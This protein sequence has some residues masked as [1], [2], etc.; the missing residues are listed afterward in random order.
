MRP[1]ARPSLQ[2]S[3]VSPPSGG[4]TNWW[5]PSYDPDRQLV[6]V[7]A[8]DG[9]SLY[10]KGPV[11]FEKGKLFL[12]SSADF[13]ANSPVTAAVRAVDA[14]TGEVSWE[15]VLEHGV[16]NVLRKVGGVLSTR[17]GVLLVGYK[18]EFAAYDSSNGA[19]LWSVGLGGLVGGPPIAYAVGGEQRI[20]VAAGSSLFVF[21]LP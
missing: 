5:P 4:A 11:E 3:L 15:I 6:Y 14:R 7:P 1:E 20:A 16:T 2:G 18:Q 12:G 13:A 19:K 21:G 8:V 17:G 9:A 10:F